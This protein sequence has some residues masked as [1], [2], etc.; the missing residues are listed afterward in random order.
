[1]DIKT[2]I[3]TKSICYWDRNRTQKDHFRAPEFD[4]LSFLSHTLIMGSI[5]DAFA[6]FR[7]KTIFSF[8]AS[9]CLSRHLSLWNNFSAPDGW[10]FMKFG[11]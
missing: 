3:E 11:I 4:F 2:I 7:K 9:V 1:M 5:L 8:V 10:I 6:K